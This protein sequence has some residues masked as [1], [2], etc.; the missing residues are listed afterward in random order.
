M[1]AT[2]VALVLLGAVVLVLLLWALA[3]YNGLI[4]LRH[5]VEEAWRQID[6]ELHR[7]YDLVP[8][9]LQTVADH[10]PQEREVLDE[11]TRARTAA[12]AP[13]ATPSRQADQENVLTAALGRLFAVAEA[14]PRLR[15]ADSFVRLQAEL[16][17]TEDHI[18]AGRRF[19]NAN[20]RQL[21]TR[22]AR[23]PANVVAALLGLRPAE[24]FEANDP[25]VRA[26]PAVSF[27]RDGAA[28]GYGR[29][30]DR[31]RAPGQ[32]RGQRGAVLPGEPGGE[33]AAR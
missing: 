10:A 16:T 3:T 8:A 18:A 26:A 19:Y 4:R 20:V 5:L 28:G 11:V 25:A 13:S 23:F 27:D 9:L 30:E 21:N 7:R 31:R 22:T 12:A 33:R 17:S 1:D 24:Y 2:G 32:A 29:P 6:V 15:T 14:Y